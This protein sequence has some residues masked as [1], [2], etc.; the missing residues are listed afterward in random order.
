M[1]KYVRARRRRTATTRTSCRSSRPSTCTCTAPA[2]TTATS[3]ARRCSGR[4]PIPARIYA[5]GENNRLKAF[6]FAQGQVAA[7]STR[8]RRARSAPD[9]MP[10]GMLSV[11]SNGSEAGTGIVWAVVPLDGDANQQRGVHRDRA[12]ARRAGRHAHSS[13]PASSSAARDRLGLFAKFV[14]ADDRR[15]Q[16]LR[17]HLRRRGAAA[18]VR[19]QPGRPTDFPTRYY[20]AVYGLLRSRTAASRSSTRIATT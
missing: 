3:T 10:G 19:R 5:W 18:R 12:G 14:A 15:R 13:G 6:T 9:G 16:G 20:V 7:M 1:G 17:R 2:R 8:R 11:S 4:A